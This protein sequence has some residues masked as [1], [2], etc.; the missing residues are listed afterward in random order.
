MGDAKEDR[1]KAAKLPEGDI[2]RILLTQHADVKD[3]LD[4]MRRR[5]EQP[6]RSCSPS[7]RSR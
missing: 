2:V 4:Q 1:A 6:E 5:L 3:L 7:S